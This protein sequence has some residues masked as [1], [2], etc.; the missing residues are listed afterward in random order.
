MGQGM[1]VE[2]IRR[3]VEVSPRAGLD[4]LA[5]EVWRA[6]GVDA[7]SDI[8]ASELCELIAARRV[9]QSSPE[10]VRQEHRTGSRP[11]SPASLERR[12]QW[13]AA[14]WLPPVLAAR[15]TS[16][17]AAALAVIVREIAV[18]GRCG[19]PMGGVAGRAGVCATTVRNA[20]REARRLGLLH[21]EERRLSHTRSLPNL[22]TIASRELALW[23]RTRS[24]IER[25][26]G[27]CR[28][29]LPTTIHLSHDQDRPSATAQKWEVGRRWRPDRQRG[30]RTAEFGVEVHS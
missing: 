12:R 16:G 19:L 30:S 8:E 25:Q 1:F 24:R 27:G 9:I 7:V 4:A 10:R 14:G 29:V 28:T 26:G 15:F 17:E 2:E 20:L 5:K 23:V 18:S 13:V 21:V 6:F 22:I 11:R 3:A